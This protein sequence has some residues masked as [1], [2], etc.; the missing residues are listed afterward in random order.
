MTKGKRIF[1]LPAPLVNS[2][3][4]AADVSFARRR[5]RARGPAVRSLLWQGPV[6]TLA[7]QALGKRGEDLAVEALE[8]RGYAILARRYRTRYG[9]IDIIAEDGSTLVFVEVKARA[10]DEFGTAAE[11]VTAGKQRRLARMAAYYL[12]CTGATDRP[13]RFDVVA[14]MLRDR[15]QPQ[16]EL[17]R[18]A[19]DVSG[20]R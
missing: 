12:L 10:D 14:I 18:D 13:C 6:V 7:R 17:F 15:A 20:Y 19:F 16:I 5:G 8:G 2:D 4:H 3:G 9:E 1:A 11:A